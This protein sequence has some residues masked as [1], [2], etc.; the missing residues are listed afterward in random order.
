MVNS[1]SKVSVKKNRYFEQIYKNQFINYDNQTNLKSTNVV[2]EHG[3]MLIIAYDSF[4]DEMQPFVDHKN[5]IGL[6]TQI[7]PIS[8]IGSTFDQVYNYIKSIF[9]TDT[10]L[11]F[12]L[13]VGDDAQIPTK[14]LTYG[15]SDASYSV[16]TN[17]NNRPDIIVGRFSAETEAQ[18]TTMVNRSIA[19][20]KMI[21]QPWF[22]NGIGIASTMSPG[23]DG[24]SDWLHL[25]NIRTSLL[26]YNYTNIS[27]L[28]DGSQGVPDESGNPT[29]SMVSSAVNSGV[30]IINYTGHG[31]SDSWGTTGFNI[32]DVNSL[33][34]DN[35]LPFIFST[36]CS[37]GNFTNHF[38]FAESWLRAKNSST[39]NPTGAIAFY[40]AS[41][42]QDAYSP[43]EAQDKFNSLLVSNSYMSFGAL[44]YNASCRM[45]DVYGN[46]GVC[47]FLT[48]TIFGDPSIVLERPYLSGP[49]EVCSTTATYTVY[50]IP[51][52]SS[53][54]WNY[55]PNLTKTSQ[56]G[57]SA[58][59]TFFGS[60]AAT[61]G[62]KIKALSGCEIILPEKV[63][64]RGVPTIT[65]SSIS[66]LQDMGYG[67]Y[68]KILPAY[69][70]Y[71]YEGT[72]SVDIPS[73]VQY[74]DW[75]FYSNM[76]KKVI[77]YWSTNGTTVD[78]G[79]KTNNAGEVLK[80]TATNTCGS[81]YGLFSFFTGDLGAP[82][83]PPLI[84]TPNPA[85]T[86][87]EVSIDDITNTAQNYSVATQSSNAINNS[88]S[89]T[90]MNSS[91]VSLYSALSSEKKMIVPTT[92]L[93]SGIYIVRVT[94]GIN[95]YQGNL[96]V[97]H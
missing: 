49:S 18:V 1:S 15:A 97:N 19:Y 9:N 81:A 40:G 68:Y 93:K 28:Y 79:A 47:S 96:V 82:P 64:W 77:A 8:S 60:G 25:R 54:T 21:D 23:D 86:Q 75:S 78:V 39:G 87:T 45:M 29:A 74:Y 20:E 27:E 51:W 89:I 65:V 31:G 62:A 83:P 43:M 76:P 44:C 32:S 69:G 85:T 16:L 37:V 66:N 4:M 30:S 26:G 67:G 71:A 58:T 57:N 59:F 92:S 13:L 33:T 17:G 2:D 12:V 24:E 63:V 91:G 3:R 5:C 88:Y 55:S 36:A 61:V 80:F 46:N 11:T 84:I 14:M 72:L 22:H 35:K 56:T 10:T 42:T 34:N 94:D 70:N 53:V 52:G 48:W 6:P 50:N 73:G 95:I 41:S 7:V 38:C 90:I